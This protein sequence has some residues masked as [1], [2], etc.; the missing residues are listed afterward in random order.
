MARPTAWALAIP[1]GRP[2]GCFFS[3]GPVSV[4]G[5]VCPF[6]SFPAGVFGYCVGWL[7][8]DPGGGHWV[9]LGSVDGFSP[10]LAEDLVYFVFGRWSLTLCVL[11]SG[12][13]RCVCRA[14]CAFAF[15]CLVYLRCL[16]WC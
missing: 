2:V 3:T 11:V 10:F 9:P 13:G 14:L 1:S 15:A 5:S 16:C 7:L 8:A 4:V 12:P 6:V